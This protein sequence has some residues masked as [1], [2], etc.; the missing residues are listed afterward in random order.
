M[1]LENF[2]PGAAGGG[3]DESKSY[4]IKGST[5]KELLKKTD[6]AEQD[7]VVQDKGDTRT[8]SLQ[9]KP[10]GSPDGGPSGDNN[11]DIGFYTC[12][13]GIGPSTLAFTLV[14]RDGLCSISGSAPDG[15]IT[16]Y[17]F[18]QQVSCFSPDGP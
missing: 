2:L 13:S 18:F 15:S 11:F 10:S 6:F 14:V 9:R 8:V 16:Y 17:T 12:P 3:V 7:F 5:L 1:P 4:L